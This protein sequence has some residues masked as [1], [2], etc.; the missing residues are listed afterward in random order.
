MSVTLVAA[1][2]PLPLPAANAGAAPGQAPTAANAAIAAD[3]NLPFPRAREGRGESAVSNASDDAEAA[4]RAEAD[5]C[6]QK[7]VHD[8]TIFADAIEIRSP[9]ALVR[10]W[11]G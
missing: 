6:R 11:G 2:P 8:W 10:A 3:L 7:H 1:S 5:F 9:T 4:Q